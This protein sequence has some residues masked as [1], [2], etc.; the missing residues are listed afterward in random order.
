FGVGRIAG[1][2]GGLSAP[3]HRASDG[4]A[5]CRCIK[6]R[7]DPP[8]PSETAAGTVISRVG[9]WDLHSEGMAL[10]AKAYRRLVNVVA[11]RTGKLAHMRLV[12]IGLPRSLGGKLGIGSMALR[13]G[14]FRHG[15]RKGRSTVARLAGD[16]RSGMLVD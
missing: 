5:A 12:G 6:P 3:A 8:R 1:G 15:L 2:P 7:S 14:R 10:V 9:L 16:A 11:G 13:A 4:D